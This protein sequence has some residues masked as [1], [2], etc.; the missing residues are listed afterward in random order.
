MVSHDLR[1]PL[2]AIAMSANALLEGSGDLPVLANAIV[3][4]SEWA[5]RMIRD[6][7]DVTAIEAGRLTIHPGADDRPDDHGDDLLHVRAA[8]D[9]AGVTL[10]VEPSHGALGRRRCRP[11]RPGGRQPRR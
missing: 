2:S 6:L 11:R 7:L 10:V 3:R 1:S 5:L 8:S 4:S 9:D